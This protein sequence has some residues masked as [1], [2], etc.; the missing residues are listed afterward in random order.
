MLYLITTYNNYIN[1]FCLSIVKH[2]DIMCLSDCNPELYRF[3]FIYE[4]FENI[5]THKLIISRCIF[6]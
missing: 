6:L 5:C 4:I 1:I 2:K 3:A